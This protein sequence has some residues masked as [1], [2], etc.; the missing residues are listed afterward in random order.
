MTVILCVLCTELNS[1]DL[2]GCGSDNSLNS[3][4][5]LPSVQCHRRHPERRVAAWA[6]CFERLLQDPVG[7]RYF[8]VRRSLHKNQTHL[9]SLETPSIWNYSLEDSSTS[10][11][12]CRVFNLKCSHVL[13]IGSKI[14]TKKCN[15]CSFKRDLSNKQVL[16]MRFPESWQII[17][18][19][20]FKY[21]SLALNMP[22]V[23]A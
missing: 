8:S 9:L 7:I 6:V 19:F 15:S 14:T 11:S 10:G 5:S 22:L 21:N 2:K 17:R 1:A 4:A 16:R 12:G 3:N 18:E 20:L 13:F 23:F